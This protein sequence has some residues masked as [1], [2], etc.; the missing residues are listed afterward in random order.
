[1]STGLIVACGIVILL[2]LFV[3]YSGQAFSESM[4]NVPRSIS[5]TQSVSTHNMLRSGGDF[6]KPGE[7]SVSPTNTEDYL[8]GEINGAHE[9]TPVF[10]DG[11]ERMGR[12]FYSQS[13]IQIPN[14]NNNGEYDYSLGFDGI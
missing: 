9:T 1:M 6:D 5:T 14:D 12:V 10:K 8:F 3:M 7:N 13:M 11:S 4:Q 2:F